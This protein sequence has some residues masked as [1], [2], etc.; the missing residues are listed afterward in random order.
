MR[1]ALELAVVIGIVFVA[2][3]F[4]FSEEKVAAKPQTD[5]PVMGG[6][7]DKT[8][9]GDYKGVR[10]YFCCN[11][12]PPE[13]N[14]DPEKY[15]K[16]L[17]DAGMAP[18]KTK[19][20]TMCPVMGGKIDKQFFGDN[21]G[22]RVY[23]CCA[24]CPKEF[25]KDP[26]KYVK[27]MEAQGVAFAKIQTVC[28]ITGKKIDKQFFADQDGKRVYFCAKDCIET[29]K[30]EPAKYV[31]QLEGRGVTLDQAPKAGASK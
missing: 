1:K 7:I 6:K 4:A 17:E 21:E 31:K 8:I 30:K 20:Q 18:E 25:E 2:V 24:A 26:A 22:K 23:F 5:C 13:F 29:F 15:I 10:V 3:G 27:K 9:Y 28:P 11:E 19:P 16:A 12:C 14:K